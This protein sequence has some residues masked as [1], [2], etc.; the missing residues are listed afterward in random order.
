MA[1]AIAEG[2]KQAD[3]QVKIKLFNAAKTD[4]NDLVT[5]IFKSKA[6]LFGSSTINNGILSAIAGLLDM[7]KGLRFRAKKGASFGAYGWSGESTRIINEQLKNAGFELV[8]E[9]IR[10]LWNPEEA[11][12]DRCREFGKNFVSQI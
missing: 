12:L 1:E 9:G 2:I 3:G 8:N 10:E 4:K 5:E 7:I 6:V 11:A